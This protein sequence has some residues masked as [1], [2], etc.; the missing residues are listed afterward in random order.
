MTLVHSP[1]AGLIPTC[2]EAATAAYRVATWGSEIEGAVAR[3]EVA[4]GRTGKAASRL[5]N[6]EWLPVVIH[7]E[8]EADAAS[9]AHAFFASEQERLARQDAALARRLEAAK[10]ARAARTATEDSVGTSASE[11][12]Q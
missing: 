1:E 10:V 5:G 3:I 11:C 8:T 6:R 12:A 2:D 9:K 7:G 4:A